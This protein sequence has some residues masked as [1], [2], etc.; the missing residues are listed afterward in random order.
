MFVML[1]RWKLRLGKEEQFIAAW[2]DITDYF[3][4]EFDSL[5][6]RL[7]LGD[8]GLYYA[9]AQW[10]SA[11]DLEKA[12]AESEEIEAGKRMSEAIEERLP[13]VQLEIMA[14][15]LLFPEKEK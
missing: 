3:R 11:E 13:S 12:F 1:Y 10:K 8:D 14:D 5:G 7:H 4:R 6:S 2:S 9:F 15:F